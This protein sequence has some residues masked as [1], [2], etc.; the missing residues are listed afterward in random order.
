MSRYD[1]ACPFDSSARAN[2]CQP[3]CAANSVPPCVAAY[4]DGRSLQLASN[5]IPLYRA[6]AL[7]VR[8]AA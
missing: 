6:D 1:E 7:P 4:L 5:V 2:R 3:C 8:K